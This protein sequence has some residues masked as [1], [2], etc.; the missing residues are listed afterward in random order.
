MRSLLIF[1]VLALAAA[2][3][4]V[5]Q[6]DVPNESVSTTS[7]MGH[8]LAARVG[9]ITGGTDFGNRWIIL[10]GYEGRFSRNWSVPVEAQLFR[11]I[12]DQRTRF[13]LSAGLK[14]RVP[15]D[16][17]ATSLYAQG[18]IGTGVLYPVWHYAGGVEYGVWDRV[19]LYLQVKKFSGNLDISEAFLSIGININ[20]TSERL[21]R[22]YEVQA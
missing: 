15:L 16:R 17:T 3:T 5:S 11:D 10:G 12:T 20:A 4:S 6:I 8:W 1:T 19:S 14:A 7:D 2:S 21:R 22:K 9:S 13:M 18:G